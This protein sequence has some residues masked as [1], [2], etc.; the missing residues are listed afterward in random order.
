MRKMNRV[1]RFFASIKRL[2]CRHDFEQVGWREAVED[3]VRYSER[4]YECRKCGKKAWIDGRK[5]PYIKYKQ[6][7]PKFPSGR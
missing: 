5:D 7:A 3:G 1:C 2:F 4:L 6:F